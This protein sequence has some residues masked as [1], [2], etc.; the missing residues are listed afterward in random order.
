MLS[1]F[2]SCE[3]PFP[4]LFSY[5]ILFL[6]PALILPSEIWFEQSSIFPCASRRCS[7]SDDTMLCHSAIVLNSSWTFLQ[8][9]RY[10]IL[11]VIFVIGRRFIYLWFLRSRDRSQKFRPADSSCPSFAWS[12]SRTLFPFYLELVSFVYELIK[13]LV[14]LSTSSVNFD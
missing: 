1:V 7:K 14:Q 2:S 5:I 12:S 11:V 10:G 8:S 4:M 9:Q 13:E 6:I 3:V